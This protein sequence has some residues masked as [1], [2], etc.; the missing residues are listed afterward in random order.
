[1]K[2]NSNYSDV[3][4]KLED[5]S[6]KDL[7]SYN[8][9]IAGFIYGSLFYTKSSNDFFQY[10]LVINKDNFDFYLSTIIQLLEFSHLKLQTETYYQIFYAYDK[11]IHM[12][13]PKLVELLMML[14]R[15][16]F[17]G[18]WLYNKVNII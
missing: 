17:I 4:T 10:L 5:F 2:N 9:I 13:S 7:N 8:L 6:K 3:I 12:N 15:V 1:M 11:L 14:C 16:F 18:R